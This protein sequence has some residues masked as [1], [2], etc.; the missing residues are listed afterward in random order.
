MTENN[1]YNKRNGFV[2]RLDAITELS[3]RNE[4][5]YSEVMNIY[6]RFN[7]RVYKSA[8]K[9]RKG[10]KA[11][12]Y[13]PTLEEKVFNLTER[14]FDIENFKELKALANIEGKEFNGIF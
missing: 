5:P 13:N 12:Y 2:S 7:N 10:N 11:M 3:V 8:N 14:Y 6:I 9:E 1:K 4:I